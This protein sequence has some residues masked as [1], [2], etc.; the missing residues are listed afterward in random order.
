MVYRDYVNLGT[1]RD[2][3]AACL[4]VTDIARG[5]AFAH[6]GINVAN[7]IFDTLSGA[8]EANVNPT[9]FSGG[10]RV[11]IYD[12]LTLRQL[13]GLDLVLFGAAVAIDDMLLVIGSPGNKRAYVFTGPTNEL[14]TLS[15]SGVAGPFA[16]KLAEAQIN[17]RAAFLP[18]DAE[19]TRVAD[20]LSA[21]QE[22][23]S[24]SAVG[25][26][27]YSPELGGADPAQGEEVGQPLGA[28]EGGP[29]PPAP[30]ARWRALSSRQARGPGERAAGREGQA[31][32][33][34]GGGGGGRAGRAGGGTGRGG[35]P[36]RRPPSMRSAGTRRS[37]MRISLCP[38]DPCMVSTSRTSFH[39]S[40][41]VSTMKAVLAAWGMSGSSSVRAMRMAN[42]ARCALEMNH[43][44][45]LMTHSSPSW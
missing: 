6:L 41:S 45:P 17:D 24:L 29:Q 2:A 4:L 8:D 1:A 3:N 10:S 34:A 33:R 27:E 15:G 43:L 21:V 5:G 25:I 31:A 7:D 16:G 37:S 23:V 19:S 12:L 22:D 13:I 40:A 35:D 20:V 30:P 36:G 9:Q 28:I 44:W 18:D 39:P 26:L 14:A 11:L 32:G 42:C 38:V